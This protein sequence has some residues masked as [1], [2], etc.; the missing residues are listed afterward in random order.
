[1]KIKREN[2]IKEIENVIR[3]AEG[4]T[5]SGSGECQLYGRVDE[6]GHIYK[7]EIHDFAGHSSWIEGPGLIHIWT[8]RWFHWHDHEDL[9]EWLCDSLSPYG[10]HSELRRP[11]IEWLKENDY[12][13]E[14][15]DEEENLC[16]EWWR[17]EDFDA[18]TWAEMMDEWQEIW[19]D[20]WLP[21]MVSEA[22][23]ILEEEGIEWV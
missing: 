14:D 2:F 12:Y 19:M 7:Y 20:H 6:D 3:R 18:A 4:W 1:M 23:H 5:G 9:G 10:S 13:D 17:F 11:F 22:I 16:C 15:G 21:E 8:V